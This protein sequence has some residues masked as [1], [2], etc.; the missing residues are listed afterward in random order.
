MALPLRLL[1][2]A[3]ID[4]SNGPALNE[5]VMLKKRRRSRGWQL[6]A[7]GAKRVLGGRAGY[8]VVVVLPVDGPCMNNAT[9]NLF[10]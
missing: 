5:T 3:T 8:V 1:W 10:E 9:I 6:I 4:M 7:F 2:R